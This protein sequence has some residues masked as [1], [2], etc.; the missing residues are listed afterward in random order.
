[1]TTEAAASAITPKSE[2]RRPDRVLGKDPKK[3]KTESRLQSWMR[4][5]I[6][7]WRRQANVEEKP[8]KV[9]EEV[10]K[11]DEMKTDDGKLAKTE[12]SN[13]STVKG[14]EVRLKKDSE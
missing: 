2:M 5:R 12:T 7:F 9:I 14:E 4:E 6:P 11:I 10:A 13:Q 3:G 8:D 1:M